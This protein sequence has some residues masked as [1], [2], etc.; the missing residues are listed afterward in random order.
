MTPPRLQVRK[1]PNDVTAFRGSYV[2]KVA[3]IFETCLRNTQQNIDMNSRL[4]EQS[5]QKQNFGST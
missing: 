2:E 3:Y 5:Q 1:S 4:P